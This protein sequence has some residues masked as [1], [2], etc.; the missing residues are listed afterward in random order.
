MTKLLTKIAEEI[1]SDEGLQNN[2]YLLRQIVKSNGWVSTKFIC[3][4]KSLKRTSKNDSSLVIEA[5]NASNKLILSDDKSKTKRVKPISEE[6]KNSLK[7]KSEL[8]TI[9]AIAS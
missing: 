7:N 1:F 8:R 3:S 4:I 9:V 2:P 6:L 5:I